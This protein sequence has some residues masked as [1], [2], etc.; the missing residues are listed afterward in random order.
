MDGDDN[1]E[2]ERVN[3]FVCRDSN[4]GK[5]QPTFS[6]SLLFLQTLRNISP[7]WEQKARC[8]HVASSKETQST[9]DG[10]T[11]FVAQS[12]AEVELWLRLLVFKTLTIV[13]VL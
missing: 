13:A 4:F 1:S 2:G 8:T 9:F 3:L 10:T 7:L 5:T 11:T 12:S 6:I